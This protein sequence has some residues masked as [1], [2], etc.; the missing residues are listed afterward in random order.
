MR[1]LPISLSHF[2]PTAIS[3]FSHLLTICSTSQDPLAA[4]LDRAHF[5][6]RA[7]WTA[8]GAD[9]HLTEFAA[10]IRQW[11]LIRVAENRFPPEY[12]STGVHDQPDV[13]MKAV[14]EADSRTNARQTSSQSSESKDPWLK[15]DP[16]L[17]SMPRPAQS[18]WEDLCH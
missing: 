13:Q 9:P 1:V 7:L 2:L 14:E 8:A 16:W 12:G 17:R 3:D 4:D 11:S 5:E 18:K 6:A 15:S 10:N